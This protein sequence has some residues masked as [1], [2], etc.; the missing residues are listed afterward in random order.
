MPKLLLRRTR[1]RAISF[2]RFAS[3]IMWPPSHYRFF[4]ELCLVTTRLRFRKQSHVRCVSSPEVSVNVLLSQTYCTVPFQHHT[5][6]APTRIHPRIPTRPWPVAGTTSTTSTPHLRKKP[7][8]CTAQSLAGRIP[9]I[10]FTI[11]AATGQ[12]QRYSTGI[13]SGVSMR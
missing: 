5:S 6:W 8:S 9:K 11:S 10:D 3:S 13:M 4:T 1:R 2:V 7:T 12:R